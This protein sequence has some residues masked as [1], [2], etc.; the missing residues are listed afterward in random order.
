MELYEL[1]GVMIAAYV[2][3]GIWQTPASGNPFE[4]DHMTYEQYEFFPE[5][6]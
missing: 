5:F 6:R 1:L 2:V 4:G 3:Y